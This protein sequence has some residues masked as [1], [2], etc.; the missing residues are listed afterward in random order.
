MMS[1]KKNFRARNVLVAV[2]IVIV[3]A[4]LCFWIY[5]SVYPYFVY[6]NRSEKMDTYGAKLLY[7]DTGFLDGVMTKRLELTEE[8]WSYLWKEL[9]L[10]GWSPWFLDEEGDIL[11][12]AYFSEEERTAPM[13]KYVRISRPADKLSGLREPKSVYERMLVVTL[14]NRVVI[15][16]RIQLTRAGIKL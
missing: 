13:E 3:F 8:E 12:P 14:G 7:D 9:I 16:Y 4:V 2:T 1:R 6:R 11:S 15:E 10:S 5:D